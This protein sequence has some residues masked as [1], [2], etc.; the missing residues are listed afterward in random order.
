MVVN[1][2]PNIGRIRITQPIANTLR[3]LVKDGESAR[4]LALN[5]ESELVGDDADEE[6]EKDAKEK[7][8]EKDGDEGVKEVELKV[9]G[10]A[11]RASPL[12]EKSI[13]RLLL[14]QGLNEDVESLSHPQKI[15]RVS[16]KP[17]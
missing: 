16:D 7:V 5:L 11:E 15:R 1:A 9:P 4:K 10:L 13:A 8:K 14:A 12:V 2:T 6:E 3:R 17:F